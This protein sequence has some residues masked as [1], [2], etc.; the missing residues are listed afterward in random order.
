MRRIEI[1]GARRHNL[2]HLDLAIPKDALVAITGVSGSGKSTL[3]FDILF[4]EGRRQYLRSIGM[5][6]DVGAEDAFDHIS[7]LSP[8]VAVGQGDMGV[9]HRFADGCFF[10]VDGA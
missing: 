7:G 1:R 6:T 9:L 10:S 5:L 2:K 8:T 4:E 3:A